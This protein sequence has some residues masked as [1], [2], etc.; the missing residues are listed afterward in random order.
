MGTER[1]ELCRAVA[2]G[3]LSSLEAL[4]QMTLPPVAGKGRPEGARPEGRASLA[5]A[6]APWDRLVGLERVKGLVQELY[7]YALVSRLRAAAG[8]PCPPVSLHMAFSGNPG[9]GKTTVARLLAQ[10]LKDLGLLERGH[11]V[12]VSRADLVGEY[13]GHTAQRTRAQLDRARGGVLFVDEA[14][15]LARGGEKDFGREAIDTLVKGME[16]QRQEL[17]LILAG[18]PAEMEQ[19]LKANPGLESRLALHLH[20]PDYR[21]GELLAIAQ[22]MFSERHYVLAP[23]VQ[24][25]LPGAVA[26][27]LLATGEGRGNARSV[28]NLVER[29]A[30]RQAVRLMREG[31]PAAMDPRRW[32]RIE[33]SDLEEAVAEMVS[34][35]PPAGEVRAGGA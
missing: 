14:Y 4:R 8:V 22:T 3:R 13:I 18:Y 1:E 28:R 20:F 16:D 12:E 24:S 27:V 33:R 17:V 32:S 15:A 7:A 2:E 6:L 9:T 5:Q 30:R 34:E 25:F 10:A 35:G 31:D 26:R 21:L 19:F 11:L 23:G 29:T